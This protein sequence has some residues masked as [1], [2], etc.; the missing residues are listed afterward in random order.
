MA[1]E[2]PMLPEDAAFALCSF[3]TSEQCLLDS[4][5]KLAMS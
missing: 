2:E 5:E 1:Y 4:Q 3:A